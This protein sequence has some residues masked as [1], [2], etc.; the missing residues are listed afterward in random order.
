M[1]L[2]QRRFGVELEVILPFCP[3]KL[4][5]GTT[6]FDKVATLLRQNGIPA[7]TED[8]AKAK[9]RSVGPDVWIVKDDETLGGSCVDFEG[10]EIVSPIL[11][12]ERDLKK[13]LNVTRLLKDTGFTTNFQTGLH[14]HHE[15]DDLEMEDW[16]RLVV[17]YY[18]TEPAFDRLVQP[19]RRGDENSHAMSTRRDV[20]IEALVEELE[21]AETVEDISN[22]LFP[23]V[24]QTHELK[25]NVDAFIK[26]GTVEFRQHEGTLEEEE[27]EHW[28]RLTQAF[29]DHSVDSPELLA[30][31]DGITDPLEA[32]EEVED[33]GP[34]LQDPLLKRLISLPGPK[35]RD[36][37][38]G[39]V[40]HYEGKGSPMLAGIPRGPRT[41]QPVPGGWS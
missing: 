23:G 6:R 12:G 19:D 20:D 36:H 15:A 24:N 39:V 4:P 32:W 37:Y 40:E 22:Q 30:V 13:L 38:I 3:S 35:T 8:E 26:H 18:L 14:V 1:S 27:V 34:R 2:S 21:E 5:R 16:R 31:N 17:N 10:V 29:V 25:M 11:A 9:P 28:V 33:D 41:R 7:M